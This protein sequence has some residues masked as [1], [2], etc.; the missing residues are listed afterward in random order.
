VTLSIDR[1]RP[2][3]TTSVSGVGDDFRHDLL[4][5][6]INRIAAEGGFFFFF[7]LL[8]LFSAHDFLPARAT[9]RSTAFF[10][11]TAGILFFFSLSYFSHIVCACH[12][13]FPFF[14][15]GFRADPVALLLF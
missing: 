8:F 1:P 9:L 5:F 7:F 15:S 3:L 10:S 11:D 12:V 6:F 2:R 13:F 14:L 4:F